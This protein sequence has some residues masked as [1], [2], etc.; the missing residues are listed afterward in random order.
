MFYDY[1]KKEDLVSLS[2]HLGAATDEQKAHLSAFCL[3]S[4]LM[5]PW[6]I[7]LRLTC[8]VARLASPSDRGFKVLATTLAQKSVEGT[9]PEI[10][11]QTI[12]HMLD[13]KDL[14]DTTSAGGFNRE[15][16]NLFIRA[17]R[18]AGLSCGTDDIAA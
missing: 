5:R 15:E 2:Q 1:R 14:S 3:S 7:V 13:G 4:G 17:A 11:R 16:L 6:G 8:F 18:M 9:L 12:E 10:W